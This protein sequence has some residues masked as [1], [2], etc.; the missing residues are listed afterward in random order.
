MEA[1]VLERY[2]GGQGNGGHHDGV[3]GGTRMRAWQVA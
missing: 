2:D 3:T 1:S